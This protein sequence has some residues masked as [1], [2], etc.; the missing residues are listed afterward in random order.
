MWDPCN[1]NINVVRE[2]CNIPFATTPQHGAARDTL[3]LTMYSMKSELRSVS[4]NKDLEKTD[5]A[6][7]F[8]A[9]PTGELPLPPL[10]KIHLAIKGAPKSII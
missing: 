5:R 9:T 3:L 6:P 8:P 7:S 1:Y 2:Q 4:Q 10:K